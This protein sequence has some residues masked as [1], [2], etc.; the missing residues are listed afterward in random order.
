MGYIL[1]PGDHALGYDL[2]LANFNSENFEILM[3]GRNQGIIPDVILV[4]KSYP[5][6]RKKTRSRNWKLKALTKEEEV[7]AIKTKNEKLKDEAD[8]E[9]F[10]RE[11]EE[12]PEL[13]AMINLYKGKLCL[14]I[15]Y[16]SPD[17][18]SCTDTH[19]CCSAGRYG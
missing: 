11:I 4:K 10:L 3:Q 12:D 7:D 13:R 17:V 6:T 8:Y 5:K 1:N 16:S 14:F 9:A 15:I 18:S 19:T 2:S